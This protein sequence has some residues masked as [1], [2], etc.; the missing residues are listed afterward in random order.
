MKF[1]FKLGKVRYSKK[2]YHPYRRMIVNK[3]TPEIISD[4]IHVAG[5]SSQTRTDYLE[6]LSEQL[7]QDFKQW[8]ID[9]NYSLT[10]LK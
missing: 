2:S 7:K 1:K 10:G 4:L 8:I 9:N 3:M 6:E 5:Y